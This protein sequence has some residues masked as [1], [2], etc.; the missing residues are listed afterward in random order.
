VIAV[1]A[2][3][4]SIASVIEPSGC[5]RYYR[6]GHELSPP[7]Y[8]REGAACMAVTALVGRVFSVEA[9][10]ELPALVRSP[11]T[12]RGHRLQRVVLEHDGL[13]FLDDRLLDTATGVPCSPRTQGDDIRCL[14]TSVVSIGLFTDACTTAVRVAELPRPRCEPVAFATT[15]RPFQLHGLT[16]PPPGTLFRRDILGCQPYTSPAGT[17][18]RGL[19]PPLELTTF[20]GGVY[21]GDRSP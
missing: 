12:A 10:L 5:A 9:P 14:P 17:E 1:G 15:N 19:G 4:P 11:E 8:R 7:V 3:V 21:F 18:L 20:A 16:D 6:V 2:T 13:R